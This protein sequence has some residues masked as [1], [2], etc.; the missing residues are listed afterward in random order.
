MWRKLIPVLVDNGYRA[1]AIDHIGTGRSDKPTKMGDYTIARHE[2][3]VKQALFEKISVKNAHFILHDWGGIIGG[4][5]GR[6]FFAR[7]SALDPCE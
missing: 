2:A 7:L 4:P 1:I 3:W 5:K 6:G